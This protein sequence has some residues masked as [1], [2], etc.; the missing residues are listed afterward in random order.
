MKK[1]LYPAVILTAFSGVCF[2]A[3]ALCTRD[4]PQK[5][6]DILKK[7]EGVQTNVRDSALPEVVNFIRC[8]NTGANEAKAGKP[9]SDPNFAAAAKTAMNGYKSLYNLTKIYVDNFAAFIAAK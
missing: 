1:I 5:A 7:R 4:V 9:I 6:V 8:V 3:S 2:D